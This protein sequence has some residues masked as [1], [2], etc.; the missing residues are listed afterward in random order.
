ML[1]TFFIAIASMVDFVY[2]SLKKIRCE[3]R[4]VLILS[5]ILFITLF[6]YLLSFKPKSSIPL[7]D[8]LTNKEIEGAGDYIKTSSRWIDDVI[9]LLKRENVS[10]EWI[11]TTYQNAPLLFYTDYKVQLIWPVKKEFLE[12]Y[13]ERFWIVIDPESD[14]HCW[15][16]NLYT[17]NVE[18]ICKNKNYYGIV[19]RCKDYRFYNNVTVYRCN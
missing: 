8:F 7:Y 10:S 11:F 19:E 14:K 16:F 15:W 4:L 6:P 1:P 17:G 12:T 18:S 5:F 13:K 2:E 9:S 3:L